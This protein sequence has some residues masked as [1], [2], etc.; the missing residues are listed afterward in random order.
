MFQVKQ[1]A[2]NANTGKFA[3]PHLV[4]S[5]LTLERSAPRENTNAST[6][7]LLFFSCGDCKTRMVRLRNYTKVTINDSNTCAFSGFHDEAPCLNLRPYKVDH[8]EVGTGN[9]EVPTVEGGVRHPNTVAGVGIL[10]DEVG[11][12]DLIGSESQVRHGHRPRLLRV[13]H[14]VALREQVGVRSDDLDGGLVRS[15]GAIAAQR[16]EDRRT[17]PRVDMERL[18]D[19]LTDL[20]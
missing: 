1:R 20:L 14:E 3:R 12:T 17:M 16:I 9:V 18:V 5:L 6:S 10:V 7:L 15:D 13:V 19:A 11:G 8:H 4:V 2:A